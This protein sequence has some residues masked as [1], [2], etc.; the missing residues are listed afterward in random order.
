MAQS[1]LVRSATY[2]TRNLNLHPTKP[3][4]KVAHRQPKH[5][6]RQDEVP[7][8]RG[9]QCIQ[10]PEVWIRHETHHRRVFAQWVWSHKAQHESPTW[11]SVAKL[12]SHVNWKQREGACKPKH[13]KTF[14]VQGWCFGKHKT[15]P[16]ERKPQ[17]TAKFSAAGEKLHLNS[18]VSTEW[19]HD[20]HF[21]DGSANCVS[22]DLP[23]ELISRSVWRSN[24]RSNTKRWLLLVHL[25]LSL[26]G[27]VQAPFPVKWFPFQ[28]LPEE[29]S[30]K[31][32]EVGGWLAAGQSHLNRL[33][34]C[35]HW[36]LVQHQRCFHGCMFTGHKSG[37]LVICVFPLSRFYE[38]L[39]WNRSKQKVL[40]QHQLHTV[41]EAPSATR[42]FLF[43]CEQ[44]KS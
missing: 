2:S 43:V 22:I 6:A 38:L 27:I 14:S 3:K 13:I 9:N 37:S 23:I 20:S 17:C 40:N 28:N 39:A 44:P 18:Q 19:S 1:W 25:F 15:L 42:I 33:A 29:Q 36:I 5:G 11:D 41:T 4:A 21:T 34:L 10:K 24:T 7:R 26:S 31:Y 30:T 16:S 12:F 35:C 32:V 8:W